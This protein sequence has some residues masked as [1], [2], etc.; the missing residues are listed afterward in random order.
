MPTRP[1]IQ[2]ILIAISG[3]VLALNPCLSLGR[4][5]DAEASAARG[6]AAYQQRCQIC[7]QPGGLGVPG[8]FPPLAGSDY[9]MKERERSIK[10]LCEGLSGK[11]T[12]NGAAFDGQMPAQ[13]LDDRAAADVLNYVG[14]VWGNNLPEFT[15]EEIA[16]VREKTKFPTA[17]KLF[18]A[19][20]FAPLP[21]PPEGYEIREVARMAAGEFGVRMA[22]R[23]GRVW[24]LTQTGSVF[25]FDPKT[26]ALERVLAAGDYL[27]RSRGGL[28]TTGITIGP[29]GRMWLTSNQEIK[30]KDTFPLDE[31]V[32]WRTPPVG[33]DGRPGKP[34]AWFR[35][36]YP[37]GG[38]FNH[39]VSHIAFG[40]DG[41][42]YVSSGS[43]TDGGEKP[44]NHP[45][46]PVGEVELTACM[47]R[48]D[49]A[50]SEP[51]VEILAR[52]LRNP[53][54]FA[55]DAAG[56]L[57]TV[58]NGP[59]AN[60]PEEMDHIVAGRHYGFPYQ[61]SDWPVLP[62]P[63][64]HTPDAPDGL[65]FSLPVKN[66]GPAGGAG[67]ATFDAHSSPAGTIWCGEDFPEPLRNAFL[68]AR[69]GNLLAESKTR[70]ADSG[71]DALAMKLTR[72]A[73]GSWTARTT[74]VLAPLGRPIDVVQS[75]PGT[76][77]ILEYTRPTNMRDGLAWLP[78]RI[79]ELRKK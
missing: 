21:K 42:L 34:E 8:V 13:A 50:A 79:I 23:A 39:G 14:S 74:T 59:D 2:L 7:H 30:R 57:F 29:D 6:E 26:S 70:L 24:V 76:A 35:A 20:E 46:S 45:A 16:K 71:F 1:S 73:D 15:A 28:Q 5:A 52:G 75:A 49:P 3:G 67:L 58:T 27:D 53:Y 36:S 25:L 10:A 64:P 19:M 51:K 22:V 61:F 48:F 77:L 44:P 56:N 78:G 47:W 60:A 32:I 68:V 41:L 31:V 37:H 55:W 43:R 4:T 66:L 54:G 40:P 38:G 72:A 18:A 12:V 63:Y 69:Y 33:T 65:K 17:A 62:K 9:L 11:I